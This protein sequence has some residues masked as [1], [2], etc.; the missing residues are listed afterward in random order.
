M[1]CIHN[2]QI[3]IG[4]QD[5]E[6]YIKPK[7]ST[8]YPKASAG[9]LLA[10]SF[11]Q[12]TTCVN[13]VDIVALR[14][15]YVYKDLDLRI[16]PTC[17]LSG[18][19]VPEN[20]LDHDAVVYVSTHEE[21]K[22]MLHVLNEKRPLSEALYDIV[23]SFGKAGSSISEIRAKFDG[24]HQFEDSLL[25]FETLESLQN[26]IPPLICIIGFEHLRYVASE[27]ISDW[28]I[29]QNN[30]RYILPLMWYDTTGSIIP[31]A[32]EGCASAIM[33]HILK[34]PGISFVSSIHSLAPDYE[35]TCC[36]VGHVTRHISRILYRFRALSH[37]QVFIRLKT[38]HVEDST[39]SS[40]T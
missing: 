23:C 19:D 21:I 7:Q 30:M 22:A 17:D 24:Q 5:V 29:K 16:T 6:K 28:F 39:K 32:L 11:Y 31:D 36:C 8:Y 34:R 3:S 20:C 9:K 1:A 26:H 25:F 35:L 18:S 37:S 10:W 2:D 38:D 40:T 4:L 27:F 13:L 15:A 12:H 33:S 14:K